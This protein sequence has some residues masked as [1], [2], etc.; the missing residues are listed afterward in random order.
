[1]VVSRILPTLNLI[2]IQI[3]AA[4]NSP[5]LSS[6]ERAMSTPLTGPG[7]SGRTTVLDGL[8]ARMHE[9]QR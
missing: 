3:P 5:E 6:R 7:G 1:M 8:T 2:D 4:F 9:A